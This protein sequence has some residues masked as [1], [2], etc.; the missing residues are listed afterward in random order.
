MISKRCKGLNLLNHL[1]QT[2][3]IKNY[4]IEYIYEKEKYDNH[5]KC[6]IKFLHTNKS[7][8]DTSY[9]LENNSKTKQK[10]SDNKNNSSM[11]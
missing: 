11:R 2:K 5:W 3:K 10:V 9:C 8:R 6:Q 1:L 7:N 4:S